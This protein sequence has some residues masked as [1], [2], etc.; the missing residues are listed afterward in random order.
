MK[1][2]I[3]SSLTYYHNF[4]KNRDLLFPLAQAITYR[5]KGQSI[6]SSLDKLFHCNGLVN[7][8][9]DEFLKHDFLDYLNRESVKSFSFDLGPSCRRVKA[10]DT[11]G[12]WLP[13][14]E[15]LAVDEIKRIINSKLEIIRRDYKGE[16]C[17]EN[18]D[19]HP[20][21]AYEFVCT[22]EFI[23]EV[24]SETNTGLLLDLSHAR[25]SAF[26][27]GLN[28]HDYI[29]KLPLEKV[30]EVHISRTGM[31]DGVL[32]DLHLDPDDNDYDLLGKVINKAVNLKYVTVE[33]YQDENKIASSYEKLNKFLESKVVI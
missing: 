4:E 32:E 25:V 7:D 9:F 2:C 31:V 28:I 8:D 3:K 14:S 27:L 13:E 16:I 22:P 30:M 11:K 18:L 24:I 17:L 12:Y 21:G 5:K 19:Y 1:S 6:D 10:H 26:H 15:I 20:G 29:D 33:Y 23:S